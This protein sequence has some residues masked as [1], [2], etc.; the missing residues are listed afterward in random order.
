LDAWSY[1]LSIAVEGL[2]GLLPAEKN[3]EENRLLSMMGKEVL[4][5]VGKSDR[6]N[7]FAQRLEGTLG[8]MANEPPSDRMYRLV[9][10]GHANVTHIAAW[11]RL[12]NKFVHPKENSIQNL[13]S[14]E[15]QELLDLIYKVTVLM[16]HIV[17][18]LIGYKGK[19]TDYAEL[20]FPERVYPLS[21]PQSSDAP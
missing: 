15:L 12:R 20:G 1:G 2:S 10:T 18:Y 3:V 11:K 9:P 6:Y 5:F 4:A 21:P 8:G 17:F 13:N 16:Y 14:S 7:K 19:Y